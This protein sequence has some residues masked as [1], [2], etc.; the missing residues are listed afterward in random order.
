MSK[1]IHSP[2]SNSFDNIEKEIILMH[3]YKSA[4]FEHLSCSCPIDTFRLS[5]LSSQYKSCDDTLEDLTFVLLFKKTA[6]EHENAQ[7]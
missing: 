1:L 7:L 5:I 2:N 6:S 3:T 4:M